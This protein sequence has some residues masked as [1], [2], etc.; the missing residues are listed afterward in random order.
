MNK[1]F[2]WLG[3]KF[4]SLKKEVTATFS[5]FFGTSSDIRQKRKRTAAELEAAYRGWGYACIDAKAEK[6]SAIELQLF[7]V[8]AGGDVI[9]EIK[10]HPLLELLVGVNE[11]MTQGDLFKLTSAHLD[12]F[13]LAYWRKL[14]TNGKKA[15]QIL[16]PPNVKKV[17]TDDGILAGY[18][19]TWTDNKGVQRTESIPLEEMVPFIDRNPFDITGGLSNLEAAYELVETDIFGTEWNR[20]FFKNN[21]IP[22]AFLKTQTGVSKEQAK[23]FRESLNERHQG[24]SKAH[25][26]GILPPNTD[27]ATA[28]SQKDMDFFN[29]DIRF[30]KKIMAVF[31]T[32]EIILGMTDDVNKAS[33]G[34]SLR[35]Y[36]SNVIQPQ[37]KQIVDTINEYMT[38]DF[39]ENIILSFES[40]IPEDSEVEDRRIK[41][42]LAD[43]P[44][45]T[46]NEIREE[47]GLPPVEGGNTVYIR[48]NFVPLGQVIEPKKK[49]PPVL[50]SKVYQK[51]KPDFSKI[52]ES[53]IKTIEKKQEEAEDEREAQRKEQLHI[54]FVKRQLAPLEVLRNRI[55]KAN[56]AFKR[57]WNQNYERI[58]DILGKK[59]NDDILILNKEKSAELVISLA[60]PVMR[61]AFK[62]EGEVTLNLLGF[63]EEFIIDDDL[64]DNKVRLLGSSYTDTMR[65]NVGKEINRGLKDG[66]T[67]N[68][69]RDSVNVNVFDNMNEVKAD[70]VADTET[71][72]MANLANKEA[73]KQAGI[74]EIAW[75]TAEDERVCEFCA[76]M[77][78]KT[79]K[80]E[81]SFFEKGETVTGSEG[82]K[83]PLNYDT[84]ETPPLHPRCRCTIE[85]VTM[86]L[87]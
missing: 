16:Y 40:P 62:D 25:I 76:P 61:Q 73:Y 67:P 36:M 47:K 53:I 28:V 49:Q 85:P 52:A 63:D 71:F 87:E 84:V 27:F 42:A 9:E 12:V 41:T 66:L 8:D 55:K 44:Y 17:F 81:K 50:V 82:G 75:Y 48:V 14:F 26:M 77:H 2:A 7:K 22:P 39:G 11:D 56:N 30:Q 79:I 29:L 68:Q 6:V 69:I 20:L 33:G 60:R 78:G 19:H 70:M 21:A 46:V 24:L 3:S 65:E 74:V 54:A 37:M 31:K 13:G 18:K 59:Q 15:L 4:S 43:N 45:M 64:I 86:P 10:I 57:D 80:I 5:A 1:L 23:R 72:R 38:K 32:P 35:T 51:S 34:A 58:I 83:L